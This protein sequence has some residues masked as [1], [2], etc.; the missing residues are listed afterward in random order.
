M[1]KRSSKRPTVQD[2][3]RLAARIVLAA[4]EAG[5]K[6]KDPLAVELGRRGGLKGGKARAVKLTSKER[7][8]IAK[9]AALAR[10][11]SRGKG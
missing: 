10:W 4:T 11:G 9:R 2:L 1:P 3:N 5:E 8:E 6:T 7:S